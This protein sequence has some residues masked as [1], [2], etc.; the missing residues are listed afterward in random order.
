[1]NMHVKRAWEEFQQTIA[2]TN[3]DSQ[4]EEIF[5]LIKDW[6]IRYDNLL[7]LDEIKAYS[8]RKHI[9][10]DIIRYPL[11]HSSLKGDEFKVFKRNIASPNR[12]LLGIARIIRDTLEQ[13]VV[14]EADEYCPQCGKYGL[15]IYQE[16]H[17]KT[18]VL[19]CN[20][21][22]YAMYKNKQKYNV[23]EEITP[24]TEESLRL[25]GYI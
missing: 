14:V 6:L 16:S 4:P 20:Q 24:A 25:S 19:E 5:S 8:L 2:S 21:C 9:E 7:L 18:I 3:D 15:G 22:G 10:L 13:L 23:G 12:N 1:M 11:K 17:S